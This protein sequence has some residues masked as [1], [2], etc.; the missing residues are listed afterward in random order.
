M[1]M[2]FVRQWGADPDIALR[3]ARLVGQSTQRFAEGWAG[4]HYELYRSLL[5]PD[6]ETWSHEDRVREG[7]AA[8]GAVELAMAALPWLILHHVERR[9]AADVVENV[10]TAVGPFAER[11]HDPDAGARLPAVAFVDISGYTALTESAGNV[12]AARATSRFEHVVT[13]ATAASQGRVVKLLGDGALLLFPAADPCVSA[14]RATTQIR[15]ELRAEGLHPHAGI[16]LGPVVERDGDIFGRTVNL[17][18][19]LASIATAGQIVVSEAV[20]AGLGA[21][22]APAWGTIEPLGEV[23]LKGFDRPVS[24]YRID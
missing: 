12:A 9:L 8:R 1:L 5:G 18:S 17:A 7:V 14:I 10:L 16:D 19:R 20:A 21:G 3:A 6:R 22:P 11:I 13:V 2:A 15:R 24:A 4:L 23:E